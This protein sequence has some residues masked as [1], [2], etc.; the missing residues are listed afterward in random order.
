MLHLLRSSCTLH[1]HHV[2]IKSLLEVTAAKRNKPEI[3]TLSLDD[4]YNNLKI[5][6]PEVKGTSSSSTNTQN[7]AFVSSN[8]TSSTNGAVN[9]AHGATTANTQANALQLDNKDLQQIHPDDLEDIDLRWQMAM[10]TM[11]ARRFLKNTR[12]KLTI[13]ESIRLTRKLIIVNVAVPLLSEATDSLSLRHL[14]KDMGF[15]VA[16]IWECIR[17]RFNEI[18][19]FHVVWFSHQIPRHAIHLWLVIKRKLKTQDLLRQWDVSSNSN[20]NSFLCP[21]CEMQSDSHEHLFFEC[22]FALQVWENL[23]RFTCIDNLPSDLNSIVDFFIPLAK[24]RSI[25]SVICKLVFVASCYFIWQERNFRLF[26]KVKRTQDHELIKSNVRLKLLSC[27]F[28]KTSNV[29]M[30]CHL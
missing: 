20:L 29:K 21:L 14:N 10:L 5:Y 17:P 1:V 25:R 7:V 2:G 30:L 9:T 19:W 23:K 4:L 12:R 24:M 6:E 3:D 18:D 28:K 16:A 8:N 15:S 22:S 26:K 11:R 27:S 13:N